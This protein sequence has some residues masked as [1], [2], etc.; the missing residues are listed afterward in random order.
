MV[1]TPKL[2]GCWLTVVTYLRVDGVYKERFRVLLPE[3]RCERL[4]LAIRHVL[5]LLT[6]LSERCL[7]LEQALLL[8]R[9][10]TAD[11]GIDLWTRTGLSKGVR[12]D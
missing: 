1:C 8:E 10:R 3:E 12:P 4:V 9:Q 5:K 6:G 7:L 2:H 11:S